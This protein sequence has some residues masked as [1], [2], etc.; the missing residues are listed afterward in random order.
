MYEEGRG[1]L[2]WTH[3]IPEGLGIQKGPLSLGQIILVLVLFTAC[4]FT[5]LFHQKKD[6]LRVA[7]V[8]SHLKVNEDLKKQKQKT[9]LFAKLIHTNLAKDLKGDVKLYHW[10]ETLN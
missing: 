5:L 3:S 6:D 9:C 1:M 10:A 8:W 2:L 4:D 7:F